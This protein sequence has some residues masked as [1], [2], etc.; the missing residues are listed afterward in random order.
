VPGEGNN[1]SGP[2]GLGDEAIRL[3]QS[4]PWVAPAHERFDATNAAV[5]DADDGLI[6]DDD[7]VGGDR[8]APAE[9]RLRPRSRPTRPA[10]RPAPQRGAQRHRRK[11]PTQQAD[12]LEAVCGRDRPRGGQGDLVLADQDDARQPRVMRQGANDLKPRRLVRLQVED[13][14]LELVRSQHVR[15]FFRQP[16][17]RHRQV[18]PRRFVDQLLAECLVC[19]HNKRSWSVRHCPPVHC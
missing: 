17:R 8:L 11:R 14:P 15:K 5:F 6:M 3:Q 19:A 12:D 10:A 4:V 13:G 2:F 18:Q 7:L 1:D 16:D 9:D